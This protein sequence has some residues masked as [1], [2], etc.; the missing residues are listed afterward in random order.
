MDLVSIFK[1]L[2]MK[3]ILGKYAG[4]CYGVRNAV[5]NTENELRKSEKIFCLGELVHNPEVMKKLKDL[6]L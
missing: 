5:L 6:G 3:I 4:F 2:N 1:E